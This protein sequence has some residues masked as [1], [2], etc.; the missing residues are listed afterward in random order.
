MHRRSRYETREL[1]F[2]VVGWVG[3]RGAR[4]I[5]ALMAAAVVRDGKVVVHFRHTGSAPILKTQ[6]FKVPA[7]ARF[8]TVTTLLRSHLRLSTDDPLVRVVPSCGLRRCAHPTP[9]RAVARRS[10][11][12]ATARLR[13][14][15][16]SSCPTWR[17]ASTL[18]ACSS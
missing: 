12:I 11:C 7:D 4:A 13:R 17:P 18:M 10:F 3:A 15:R 6:K 16:M 1:G 8:S 14:R 2:G 5:F 9:P